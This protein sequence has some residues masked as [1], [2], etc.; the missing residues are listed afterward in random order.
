MREEG[1]RKGSP[2]HSLMNTTHIDYH[3]H[4][5]GANKSKAQVKHQVFP[6]SAKDGIFAQQGLTRSADRNSGARHYNSR[7]RINVIH[8]SPLPLVVIIIVIVL[9]TDVAKQL[10]VF[11]IAPLVELRSQRT[12]CFSQRDD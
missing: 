12:R 11:P 9:H 6:G 1:E 5:F 8:I 4:R 3:T 10:A 7:V 2:K